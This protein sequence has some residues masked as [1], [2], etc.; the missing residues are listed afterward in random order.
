M[1]PQ[2]EI[3]SQSDW[4]RVAREAKADVPV[5][6]DEALDPYDPNDAAA[7][8]AYWS[9]A[10]VVQAGGSEPFAAVKQRVR[11]PQLAP[12]KVATAIRLSP[13]VVAYFKSTGPGWQTR[14]NAALE[15]YIKGHTAA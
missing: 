4:A 11:G 14:V 3:Q 1:K 13:D 6:F 5:P 12:K 2:K 15:D 8:D 7:V 9:S 10:R